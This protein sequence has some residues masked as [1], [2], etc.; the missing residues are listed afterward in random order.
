MLRDSYYP[1]YGWLL[2]TGA[3]IFGAYLAWDFGLF[4]KLLTQDITYLSSIIL[5]LFSL[6]TAYL[7]LAAWK[8]SKQIDHTHHYKQ[9]K[10]ESSW[11]NEHL[12]LLQWQ[13]KQNSNESESLLTRLVERIHRGHSNGW[14]F[15]DVL[16][17]LGLIGTVIGFVLML[18]TVYELKDNDIQALKSLLSTMGTGMQVALYTTLTGLGGALLISIQCQWLDR[19]AD[20]L[21]SKIIKIGMQDASAVKQDKTD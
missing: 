15:S 20:G 19:C 17:R 5:I 3:I 2:I 21:V 1:F 10:T 9:I 14:F 18:S 16:M 12:D 11:V 6:V 13:R 7:G 8:L 4:K